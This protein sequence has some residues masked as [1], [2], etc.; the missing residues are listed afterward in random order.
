M[1]Y[2]R[3]KSGSFAYIWRSYQFTD[4]QSLHDWSHKCVDVSSKIKAD[5]YLMRIADSRSSIY[6]KQ[7]QLTRDEASKDDAFV[8]ELWIGTKQS[9][10]KY[11]AMSSSE[12]TTTASLHK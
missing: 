10:G 3:D 9:Y 1:R 11:Q 4:H 6:I 5:V 7:I 12:Q 8:D 2:T